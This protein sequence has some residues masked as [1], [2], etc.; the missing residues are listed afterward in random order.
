MKEPRFK[1]YQEVKTFC[2]SCEVSCL[3][4]DKIGHIVDIIVNEKGYAYKVSFGFLKCTFQEG[5]LKAL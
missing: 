4:R 5:M 2:G 3:Q 1:K